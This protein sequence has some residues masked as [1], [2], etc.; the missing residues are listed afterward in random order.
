ME[1]TQAKMIHLYKRIIHSLEQILLEIDSN[2]DNSLDQLVTET[3][4]LLSDFL[5]CQLTVSKDNS[6]DVIDYARIIELLYQVIT[7]LFICK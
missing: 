1:A 3:I 4:T 7:W 5:Q 2:S 6:Q